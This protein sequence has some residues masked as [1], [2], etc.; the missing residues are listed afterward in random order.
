VASNKSIAFTY[1]LALFF[2]VFLSCVLIMNRQGI[3]GV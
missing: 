2:Q 1:G 3:A